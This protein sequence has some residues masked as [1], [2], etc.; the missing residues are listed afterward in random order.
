M[1]TTSLQKNKRNEYKKIN[2]SFRLKGAFLFKKPKTYIQSVR[3]TN[4]S[5]VQ[6]I[7]NF[8]FIK[9]LQISPKT[10]QAENL[11]LKLGDLMLLTCHTLVENIS[12]SR[13]LYTL[14]KKNYSKVLRSL[15]TTHYKKEFQINSGIISN[16]SSS[17]ENLSGQ[18]IGGTGDKQNSSNSKSKHSYL[19]DFNVKKKNLI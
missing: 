9:R 19:D 13:L 2:P 3:F 10:D 11:R 1:E 8:K 18:K 7:K 5:K 6:Q 17:K 12:V 16:N 14:K 15:W 4:Y